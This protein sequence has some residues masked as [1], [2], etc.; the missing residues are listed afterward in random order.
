MRVLKITEEYRVDSEIE[1]KEVMEDFRAKAREEGYG[2]GACGYTHKEKK[3]K[4]EIIDEAWVVRVVKI[5]GGVW[6]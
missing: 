4:G 3:L 5:F 1:A 6:E 2:L